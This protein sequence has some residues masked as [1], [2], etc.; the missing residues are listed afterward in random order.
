MSAGSR[1]IFCTG[2]AVF[3]A[4]D[5]V[6]AKDLSIYVWILICLHVGNFRSSVTMGCVGLSYEKLRSKPIKFDC[7]GFKKWATDPATQY[8]NWFELG[9]RV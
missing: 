4:Y 8:S 2:L 7:F 6:G 5:T 3:L 9:H 1:A